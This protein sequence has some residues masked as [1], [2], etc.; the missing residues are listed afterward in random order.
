MSANNA[1][2]N[3]YYNCERQRQ[4]DAHNNSPTMYNHPSGNNA[5]STSNN[6]P[7]NNGGCSTYSDQNRRKSF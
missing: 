6:W 1:N 7:T 4:V 5:N 2:G 3:G